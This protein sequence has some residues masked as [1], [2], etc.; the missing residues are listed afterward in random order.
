M[1]MENEMKIYNA[2]VLA[3]VLV[4]ASTLAALA[5]DQRQVYVSYADINTAASAG[6]HVLRNRIQVASRSVCGP[7]PDIRD[8]DR[9]AP[10]QICLKQSVTQA[11]EGL[12]QG[13]LA[14]R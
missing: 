7:A 14:S 8:L 13:P 10:Y 3:T 9:V 6:M 2:T 5:G 1:Q 11:L 12:P 4:A